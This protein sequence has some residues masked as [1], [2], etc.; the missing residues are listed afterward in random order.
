MTV[1]PALHVPFDA[2]FGAPEGNSAAAAVGLAIPAE[3]AV[4]FIDAAAATFVTVTVF[5]FP[6]LFPAPSSAPSRSASPPRRSRCCL[7]G[8][9]LS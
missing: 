3:A 2:A 7:H 5:V 9:L 1:V 8:A 6:S 4:G